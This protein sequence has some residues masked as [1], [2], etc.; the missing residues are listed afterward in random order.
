MYRYEVT[1]RE[2]GIYK[3]KGF[4]Y[5]DQFD[6]FMAKALRN[7]N[8]YTEVRVIVYD[9]GDGAEYYNRKAA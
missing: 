9:G 3:G 6:R 7:P 1:Y 5:R 4:K 2:K 8:R